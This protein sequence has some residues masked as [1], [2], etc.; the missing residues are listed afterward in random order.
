[1]SVLTAGLCR[2]CYVCSV[3]GAVLFPPVS[4]RRSA[5]ARARARAISSPRDGVLNW[6]RAP[7]VALCVCVGRRTRVRWLT[8]IAPLLILLSRGLCIGRRTGTPSHPCHYSV[9]TARVRG[10]RLAVSAGLSLNPSGAY[11]AESVHANSF[12]I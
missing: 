8:L 5:A 6:S 11:T 12:V 4:F 7:D 2:V 9:L 10:R 1:V 3:G